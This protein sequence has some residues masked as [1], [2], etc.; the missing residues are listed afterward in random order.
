VHFVGLFYT[1]KNS[2]R[3]KYHAPNW[4]G[5]EVTTIEL[6]VKKSCHA[7]IFVL[8]YNTMKNSRADIRVKMK[9]IRTFRGLTLFPSLW[10]Q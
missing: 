9:N 4:N 5:S 7:A 10:G 8:F 1:L 3:I 6:A 2:L